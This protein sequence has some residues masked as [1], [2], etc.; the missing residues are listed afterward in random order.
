[1]KKKERRR[2]AKTFIFF[3]F[4]FR[5]LMHRHYFFRL[6]IA[7]NSQSRLSPFDRAERRLRDF[8]CRHLPLSD[9]AAR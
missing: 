4:L 6:L 1:M 8:F 9:L 5:V 2:R 7:W 3:S